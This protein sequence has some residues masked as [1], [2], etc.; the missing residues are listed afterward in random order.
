MQF[1]SG[2]IPPPEVLEGINRV[3]P[4]AAE[5]IVAEAMRNGAHRRTL[6]QRVILGA[7][8]RS[9]RGQ[10]MALTVA[11]AG[12]VTA[13]VL[14]LAGDPVVGGLFAGGTLASLVSVFIYGSSQQS[15][16]RRQRAETLGQPPQ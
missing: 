9:S 11:M 3:V 12:F 5:Q 7:E 4:G 8:I 2:P 13:I 16:E 15:R 1:S 10:W 6:E 14:A